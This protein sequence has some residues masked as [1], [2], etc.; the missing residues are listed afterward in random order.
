MLED[1]MEGVQVK[2]A[3]D[4]RA[5]V[6]KLREQ[7]FDLVLC[8]INLPG[9]TGIEA[10]K[11]IKFAPAKY[12]GAHAEHALGGAIRHPRA[13]RRALPVTSRKTANPR[14]SSP[15]REPCSRVGGISA[16]RSPSSSPI[17]WTQP[18]QA[19]PHQ[20]LSDR[21]HEVFLLLASGKEVKEVACGAESQR[22]NHLDPPRAHPQENGMRNNAALTVYAV[23]SGWSNSLALA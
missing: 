21:E 1:E 11:E 8:D 22:E 16:R 18:T 2:G 10:L 7:Q 4:A 19:S 15:L 3:G 23:K 17:Q 13:Q 20:R 14:N 5:A 9:G 6:E 12:S